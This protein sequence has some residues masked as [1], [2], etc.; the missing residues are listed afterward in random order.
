MP[1]GKWF[2][3]FDTPTEKKITAGLAKFEIPTQMS[4]LENGT[5]CQKFIKYLGFCTFIL[6][7]FNLKIFFFMLLIM[8]GWTYFWQGGLQIISDHFL[9]QL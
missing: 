4:K 8:S 3:L 9:K 1:T 5:V 2:S 7:H 6:H